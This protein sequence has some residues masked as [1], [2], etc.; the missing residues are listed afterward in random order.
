[1]E[2][3]ERSTPQVEEHE[4]LKADSGRQGEGAVYLWTNVHVGEEGEGVFE[5]RAEV[6]L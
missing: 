1:M 5:R 6:T 3:K 2:N 4:H